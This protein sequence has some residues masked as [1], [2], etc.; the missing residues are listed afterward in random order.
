M[1]YTVGGLIEATHYN[2]FAASVNAVW[3]TGT[4]DRGYGQSTTLSTV[5]ATA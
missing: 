1:A 2:G 4:G 3:G 5:A